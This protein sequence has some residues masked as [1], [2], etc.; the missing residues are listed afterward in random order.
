MSIDL[1]KLPPELQFV[2]IALTK[3]A[4]YFKE[5]GMGKEFY[6]SFCS[7]IWD[8][9]ELT[10]LECLKDALKKK[11]EKDINPYVEEYIRNK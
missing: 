11:M 8:S 6:L 9:M 3:S 10:G 2:Y 7:E 5:M 1:E 4:I